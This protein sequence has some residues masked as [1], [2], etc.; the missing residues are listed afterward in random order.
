MP[1][2]LLPIAQGGDGIRARPTVGTAPTERSVALLA[3]VYLRHHVGFN[4]RAVCPP[5]RWAS[6]DALA[7]NSDQNSGFVKNMNNF[8]VEDYL[9]G[10]SGEITYKTTP[11]LLIAPLQVDCEELT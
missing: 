11:S 10:L 4:G 6:D 2:D 1:T 5:S 8:F 9:A 3:R 7:F